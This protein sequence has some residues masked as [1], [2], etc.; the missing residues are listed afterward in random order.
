MPNIRHELLIAATA[1]KIYT[2]ITSKQGLAGWWTPGAEAKAERGSI[3]H[4]AFGPD[5]FKEMKITKLEPSKRVEWACTAGVEEWV[6]TA[7]SFEL[8][9]GDTH[10]LLKSHPEAKGQLEQHPHL[11]NGTL[12]AFAH[13]N[14]R[15]YTPMFAECNYTW[16]RF[17]RSLKLLCETGAGMPWPHQHQPRSGA[18]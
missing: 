18:R 12:L 3:A 14:W 8:H 16:G 17:L 11:A 13:D 7:L 5:Y 6:G 4:F 9:A 1:D 10:A 15:S 2:A